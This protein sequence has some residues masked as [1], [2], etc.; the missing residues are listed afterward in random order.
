MNHTFLNNNNV[1]DDGGGDIDDDSDD[2]SSE[3]LNLGTMVQLD[4]PVCSL[5]VDP[6]DE[7]LWLGHANVCLP[8][9]FCCLLLYSF[10]VWLACN[11]FFML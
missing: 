5:S 1:L 7:L 2:L 9:F 3:W 6:F 8:F 10:I 4:T 11:A